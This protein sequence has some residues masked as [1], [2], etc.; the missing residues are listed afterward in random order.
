MSRTHELKIFEIYA[1]AIISGEKTFEI[2][3]NDRGFQ[4]GDC[5]KFQAVDRY[6]AVD[7][8]INGRVYSITYVLNG[9][10]LAADWVA[11]SIKPAGS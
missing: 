6:G 5:V 1:D 9:W 2:R 3:K 7:H 11:F 8:P 10:G 4:K